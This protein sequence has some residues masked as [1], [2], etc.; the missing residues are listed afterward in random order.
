MSTLGK[1]GGVH[2]QSSGFQIKEKN[3]SILRDVCT[4]KAWLRHWCRQGLTVCIFLM[5]NSYMTRQYMS[6]R[7]IIY[8]QYDITSFICIPLKCL[9]SS[10]MLSPL[11]SALGSRL[12]RPLALFEPLPHMLLRMAGHILHKS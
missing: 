9:Q 11:F 3:S 12:L 7:L 1:L 2:T 4:E 10:L 8:S 6:N 5:T